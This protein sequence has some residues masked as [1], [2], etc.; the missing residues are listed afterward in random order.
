MMSIS[1]YSDYQVAIVGGGITGLSSA[2][3]LQE[4]AAAKGIDLSYVL[5]EQSSRWGGKIATEEAVTETGDSFLIEGGPD[6][7]I[8]QKPW[9]FKL[10]QELGIGEQL[11]AT[12]DANKGVFVLNKGQPTLLP[13]GVLLIVPTK[14]RPFALS[15][16]LSPAGK[17]RMGMDLFIPAKRDGEDE[18]LAEFIQRRL[19]S[20]A[21][22]KIAEPL[23]AGIYNAEAEKQSLLAT[24]PRFR[25]LEE[26]HGSLIRGMLASRRARGSSRAPSANGHP[27][28]A[29]V[30]MSLRGG[31]RD[32]VN[33]LHSRLNG[34]LRL[35]TATQSVRPLP[36]GRYV[37]YLGDGTQITA[38]AVILATPA[39]VAGN[40]IQGWAPAASKQL[41]KI[42]YVSTGTISVAYRREDVPHP[43]DAFGLVI[44]RSEQRAINAVT[45]TSTKFDRRAPAGHVLMRAFFGGSRHPEMM[46]LDDDALLAVV[47]EELRA[48][49]GIEAKPHLHRIFR[50]HRANPQ[51]DVGHL[52]RVAAI[53]ASLP[54]GLHVTGS[55]YRGIGIPDCV[56]QAQ[57]TAAV[58][59]KQ[60]SSRTQLSANGTNTDL[61]AWEKID[62]PATNIEVNNAANA[63]SMP[64]S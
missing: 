43:L 44:P 2:W 22:D 48:L 12:N 41:N 38:D 55:P 1:S 63:R 53:E 30:F 39:Y 11:L 42:R 14:L 8:T 4:E 23:M 18:T 29:S 58:V 26:K 21:L 35:G 54:H 5:L 46:E 36:D 50:W 61:L 15:P 64:W 59:V 25:T 57:Q 24:F 47:Q 49:L 16:L 34:E 17:L 32:L 3:Y 10:A 33:E 51:Y 60:L 52:E 20:E 9:A 45:W 40:L 37:I 13:E 31:M 27:K 19:G 56:H 7:F 28:P 6:S 62:N